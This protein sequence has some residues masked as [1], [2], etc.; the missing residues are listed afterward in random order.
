MKCIRIIVEQILGVAREQGVAVSKALL[1]GC[2][3]SVFPFAVLH[4]L[5]L[6]KSSENTSYHARGA[7]QYR[8]MTDCWDASVE[9]AE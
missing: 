1:D 9:C 2:S 5:S 7:T 6:T 4:V 8:P 3:R